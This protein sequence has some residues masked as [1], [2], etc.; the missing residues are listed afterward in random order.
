[1]SNPA[2]EKSPVSSL[3]A[4][5]IPFETPSKIS[6]AKRHSLANMT[7][8][9]VAIASICSA[10]STPIIIRLKPNTDFPLQSLMTI[11]ILEQPISLYITPSKLA[12]MKPSGGATHLKTPDDDAFCCTRGLL[13]LLAQY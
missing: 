1:M 11:P 6:F 8:K 4:T 7:A 3:R 9:E 10:F 13:F 2:L 5:I 12:L